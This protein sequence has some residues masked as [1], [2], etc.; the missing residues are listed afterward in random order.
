L[1]GLLPTEREEGANGAH[2]ARR[3]DFV[4]KSH[5]TIRHVTHVRALYKGG[6]RTAHTRSSN[7][8]YF[9][10][11]YYSRRIRTLALLA[12]SLRPTCALPDHDP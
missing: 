9:Y 1:L 12:Y 6:A 7:Q 10:L 5:V 4:E 3:V 2:S 8:Q 11:Y